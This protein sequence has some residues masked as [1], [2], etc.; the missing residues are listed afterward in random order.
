MTYCALALAGSAGG[1]VILLVRAVVSARCPR[2]MMMKR[3][4]TW[5]PVAAMVLLAVACASPTDQT[6]DSLQG[7]RPVPPGDGIVARLALC[8]RPLGL[9]VSS[10]GFA[11]VTQV[12]AGQVIRLD[13][14][15]QTFGGAVTVGAVP[16]DVVFNSS[17]TRAYVSNQWS[18]TVG[19]IDVAADSQIDVIPTQGDPF[20]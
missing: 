8:C 1:F 17:G 9:R 15:T 13:P 7:T 5:S 6:N 11:Y 20:A 2:R 4:S 18:Q 12:D 10:G 19:I 3:V 14:A 16:S